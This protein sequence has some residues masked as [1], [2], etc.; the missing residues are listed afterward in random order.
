MINYSIVFVATI[1]PYCVGK[2]CLNPV[3]HFLCQDLNILANLS[4]GRTGASSI[5][6]SMMSSWATPAASTSHAG[7][8]KGLPLLRGPCAM[9]GWYCEI[10]RRIFWILILVDFVILVLWSIIN[11]ILIF[12]GWLMINPWLLLVFPLV[13][14][15]PTMKL[16]WESQ[17]YKP[18]IWGCSKYH[19]WTGLGRRKNLWN[20]P[21]KL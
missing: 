3:L 5:W 8:A 11:Q 2:T 21:S 18:T 17:C 15:K 14:D 6:S 4:V 13:L 10:K 7:G 12:C 20:W 1:I 9:W 19:R 16:T